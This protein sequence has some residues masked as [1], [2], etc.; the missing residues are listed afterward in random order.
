[1]TDV[2][3]H[4]VVRHDANTCDGSGDAAPGFASWLGLAGAPTFA[5]MA[6][7]S[8]FF[9]SQPDMIC[10]ATTQDSAPMSGMTVMYLLMSAF[11]SSPWLNL[12]AGRSTLAGRPK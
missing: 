10:T 3:I 5:L 1:M 12:I 8:A 2:S 11:H 4:P 7:W 9:S 6:L